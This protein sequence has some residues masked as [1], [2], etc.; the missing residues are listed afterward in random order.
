MFEGSFQDHACSVINAVA[1]YRNNTRCAVL[2]WGAELWSVLN[3]FCS[4]ITNM[5]TS[6]LRLDSL[7]TLAALVKKV[8]LHFERVTATHLID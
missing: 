3:I 5:P 8:S 1:R 4:R 2:Q 7:F 6:S